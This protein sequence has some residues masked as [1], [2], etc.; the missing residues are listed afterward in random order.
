MAYID[1][2]SPIHKKT[3]R[4]YLARVNELPKAQAATIAKRF[5]KDYWDGDR[6]VGY[7]GFYYDGRWKVVAEEL[8]KKYNL[9]SGDRVL[10]VGCGKGFLIYDLTQMVPGL[11][12]HG[13]DISE[14]GIQNAKQEVRP[15]LTVGNA[16]KLPFD[17]HSFDLVIS[18]NTLHNL[19]CYD[20][21]KAF[22][23]IER[24][25]K[26]NKYLVVESYRNEDEKA[27]LLYWQLTC[28]SFYT[29]EEWEWWFTRTGYNGDHSFI[30][31]E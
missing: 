18:I 2:L 12:V 15:Y 6:K 8:A 27:N 28:E 5:D 11:E 4:D 24:V 25:G 22:K 19:H 16:N 3:K 7:G 29:P 30:Y 9:K 21:E 17:D 20:L 23:E 14:Y 1:L 13:I 10:D 31:F 26:E